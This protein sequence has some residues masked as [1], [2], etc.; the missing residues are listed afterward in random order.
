M[1]TKRNGKKVSFDARKI[2]EAIRKAMLETTNGVNLEVISKISNEIQLAYMNSSIQDMSVEEIQDMVEDKLVQHGRLDVAKTYIK[3]RYARQM[4]RIQKEKINKQLADIFDAK[5]VQNSN[6]NVDEKS[7]SGKEKTATEVILKEYA[8]DNLIDP[9]VAQAHRDGLVYTHDLDKYAIGIHNCLN[10]DVG[11]LLKNGFS[12][13]N[14]D[15]RPANRFSTACQLVAVIFQL[16]SQNQYGGVGSN[17]IDY[18]L[19]PYVKKSFANHLNKG[20]KW[21]EDDMFEP[22][23]DV[24]M[25]NLELQKKYPKAWAYALEMMEA[26][27]LQSTQALYHNLNTLESRAG[28]QVPF[29]SLNYGTDTSTEG[30]KVSEWLLHASVDGIGK[31]NVTPIFP[32]AI[33]KYK[34]GI[35]DIPGTPNYHLRVLAEKSLSKRIYPNIVNCDW[36]MN[37]EDGT[38]DTEMSTMGCVEGQEIVNYIYNEKQYVEGIERMWNRVNSPVIPHKEGE[39][40]NTSGLNLEVYDGTTRSFV[41]VKKIIKNED[42]N[43]WVV[44]KIKNGRALELTADHPLPIEGKGRTLVSD[45][46]VGDKVKTNTG[47]QIK[48]EDSLITEDEAWMLGVFLCDGCYQSNINATFGMDEEDVVKKLMGICSS[49]RVLG[50][51]ECELREHKRGDRGYYL[52]VLLKGTQIHIKEKFRYIFGGLNKK[53]RQIPN[54]IFRSPRNVRMAFLGGMVDAD[55]HIRKKDNTSRVQLGSTNKELSL[56]TMYLAQS[57]GIPSKVYLNKYSSDKE[58]IRY[59]IEFGTS[60]ELLNHIFSSKK[61]SNACTPSNLTFNE[62]EEILEIIPKDTSNQFSYDLE[63]ETDTFTV[64]GV[65]SHNCRTF[66]M[67]DRHGYGYRKT[68]RGNC[69]PVTINLPMI[70]VKN[71]LAREDKTPDFEGFWND[72]RHALEIA[73]KGLVDRF[74]YICSQSTENAPFMYNN[75][76]C[77]DSVE[78]KENGIYET[79]KHF[80]L[81]FGLCGVAEMCQAMIGANHAQ[82][83]EAHAFALQVY[84]FINEFKN[85]A[86]ERRNLNFA[87]YATPA[88]STAGKF[89]EKIIEKYG[90]IKGVTDKGFITNSHHAPV[91]EELSIKDKLLIEAPFCKYVTA[92]C[93]TYVELESSVANN[94]EAVRSI[95]DYAMGLDIPYLAINFPIDTCS[96]CGHTGEIEE[97]CPVCGSEDIIRLRR[98]TGYL[99]TDY[100]N[101]NKSKQKEVPLRHKHSKT[102]H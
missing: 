35:N 102:T 100:R 47:C 79:M 28:S 57:L 77:V 51:L 53:D 21:F 98:V 8:L 13:R 95:I 99:T 39:H 16:Q 2:E 46:E 72:L 10:A 78:A 67:Y 45:L 3:Y 76:I 20:I 90:E 22:L 48:E 9:E 62:F 5:N 18:Q 64:S 34:K 6:A 73:E 52:E 59:R 1:I 83:R 12:T 61:R 68:G 41:K 55:G 37:K 43:D 65:E 84:D 96:E 17:M 58:K 86:T 60:D 50:E 27:G 30:Q 31:N 89:C 38:P 66:T 44:L 101:F 85:E 87:M 25:D 54:E 97:S 92:G 26:E 23:K 63:T 24:S 82:S 80:T 93:I 88:E 70:A 56:Q 33:F 75:G 15:V 49:N 36:S 71:S 74:N 11:Y 91:W 94:T 19:A 81:N 29:T 32:I 69:T 7:A 4:K 14:G 42:K 40:K